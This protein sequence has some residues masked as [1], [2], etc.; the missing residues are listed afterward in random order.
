MK[1][2]VSIGLKKLKSAAGE[3]IHGGHDSQDEDGEFDEGSMI[4]VISFQLLPPT[5]YS[6][7]RVQGA[8]SRTIWSA[9]GPQS[10]QGVA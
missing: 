8:P 10:G 5:P 3:M 4:K 6:A 2:F 7:A 1:K 9:S